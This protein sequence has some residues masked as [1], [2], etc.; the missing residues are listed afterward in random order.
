[1]PKVPLHA[2]I[3]SSD[4]R[5]YECYTQGQ[6]EQ[7]FRP[8]DEARWL[9]WLREVS[10]FAFHGASGSLN[11]YLEGRPRGG[12]YWYAYHT[13]RDRTRKRYLGRMASVSLAHLEET[14]RALSHEHKPAPATEQ[15]VTLLSTKLA[16]P[17]LPSSLVERARLLT[18][19]EGALAIPLTLLS[20]SAGWGKTTL[21]SAWASRHPRAVAWLSL[22]SLDNDLFRFWAAVI[23]ALRTCLPGVGASALAMAYSP[24]PPPFPSLLT[25]LLNEL[26]EVG[27]Q[28]APILLLLDDYQV[29][30]DQA[31]HEAVA[32]WV[33]HLP[34]NVHLLISSRVDPDLPLP[35]WRVRGQLAEIRAADLRF[36]PEEAGTFLRQGMGLS[37]SEEEVAALEKHTEGWVAAL[38]LAALSMRKRE[39]PG[40]WVSDFVGS[41]RYLLDYVQQEILAQLPETLQDFLL[42]TSILTS[43]NAALC[44]AVTAGQGEPSCQQMLV[45][46]E[47]AN[48]F[49]VP[50]DEQRQWYRYHDLFREALLAR[51]HV[52]QP[53]LVSLLHIRAARWYEATAELREA[54]THAFAAPDHS[55]AASLIEQA[56]PHFWLSGEA[57][58]ILTWVLALPDAFLYAHARL[59]LDAALRSFNSV[60][61]STELVHASMSA[62]L[63]QTIARLEKILS[64]MP[65]QEPCDT[66]RV[67]LERR[68]RVLQALSED[69]AI[70]KSGDTKRLW[71]L[72]EALEALPADL[73]ASW[74][75]I[76]L[77]ITSWLTVMVLGEGVQLLPRL[78]SAKQGVIEAGDHLAAIRVMNRLALVY[79][80]AGQLQL[81]YRECREA[82]ALLLLS[83]GHTAEAGY[84][85][86]SLF[87]VSY[88]RNRLEEA[89][90][91][92]HRLLGI[93]QDWQHVELLILGHLCSVQLSL[94]A[95]KLAAARE[96]LHRADALIEQ[97]GFT[98]HAH[99]VIRARVRCW[100][101]QG[102]LAQADDWA[103][104][105]TFPPHTRDLLRKEEVLMLVRVFLAQQQ[106]SQAVE[107]LSRCR[108]HLDLPADGKTT[109]DFLALTVV[110]LHQS[111][112]RA[113]ARTVAARLLAL[114]EPEGNMRVY[115]DLG[116]PMKQ[117]L[118]TLL[119]PTLEQVD[120]SPTLTRSFLANLVTAFEQEEQQ[121]RTSPVVEPL[122][123]HPLADPGKQKDASLVPVEPLTQREQEV[124]RLLSEGASNQEIA[125]AL[126]IELS[127]VKKHVSNLLGKLGAESRTQAIAQARTLSLL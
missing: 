72:A 107:I 68:L 49:V 6:L 57:R 43:M 22:D 10:S 50:L 115:L 89:S 21:L 77:S 95:G 7:R 60:H 118:L 4:Q 109:I 29:I 96:G 45:A 62:Q 87:N 94:A 113:Q 28:S 112:K 42:H 63:E 16:P 2:L 66:E 25:A 122:P 37:L 84:L 67:L 14:A 127:T 71:H 114:T 103:A 124:L 26:T 121:E 33:E 39:D 119:D 70:H 88:A 82:L 55:F 47:H 35:R 117:V 3:W 73:E 41:H 81:A 111:R 86:Y 126:V 80:R 31:I 76:P 116:V 38:Q 11:V 13:D 64:R 24:Q 5:L 53:E 101:A 1:M 99:W 34:V 51:L 110:A 83:G 56:A 108:E 69:R 90:D 23:A 32:F 93:A 100:L 9:T 65:E 8:A 20:A 97:E 85:Y 78:L 48:L 59:A 54:I 44:Q 52:S 98:N 61:F 18:A 75:M 102:N 104:Q 105:I 79:T 58:T 125:D 12:Q 46:L 123:E 106:Y 91:A 19:L 40:A 30:E 27:D 17:R 36:C 92:L 15:D 120:L 74:N